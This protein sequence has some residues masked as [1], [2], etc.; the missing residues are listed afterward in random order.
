MLIQSGAILR[1]ACWAI[2]G[3]WHFILLILLHINNHLTTTE[4]VCLKRLDKARVLLSFLQILQCGH[5]HIAI[6]GQIIFSAAAMD[7]FPFS[8]SEED[9]VVM[10]SLACSSMP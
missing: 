8:C 7:S 10:P 1:F 2:S 9:E 5:G 3:A 4:K 6:L